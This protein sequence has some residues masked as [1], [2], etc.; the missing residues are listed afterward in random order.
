MK[1]VY[2][3]IALLINPLSV[4]IKMCLSPSF[5]WRSFP[6]NL[7]RLPLDVKFHV[8]DGDGNI[9]VFTAHKPLLACISEVFSQQFYGPTTKVAIII[10]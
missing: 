8:V 2:F 3:Q 10:K 7:S 1:K 6:L 5:T 4:K 9:K